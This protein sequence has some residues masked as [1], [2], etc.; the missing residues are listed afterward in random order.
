ML[1]F[2]APEGFVCQGF[3]APEGF[4]CHHH[5][6]LANA[7]VRRI[8][9]VELILFLLL[10]ALLLN[11]PDVMTTPNLP[12]RGCAQKQVGPST[13]FALIAT[14]LKELGVFWAWI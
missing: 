9:K 6:L 3:W 11:E 12:V 10:F 8:V 1:L 2:A 5:L 7:L 4:A 13:S 14:T